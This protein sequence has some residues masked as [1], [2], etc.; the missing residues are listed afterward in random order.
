MPPKKSSAEEA[1]AWLKPILDKWG[2]HFERF[3]RIFEIFLQMQET[4]N[5]ILNKLESLERRIS[6]EAD[7]NEGS[8]SALYSTLVK[9]KADSRIV[10]EKACMDHMGGYFIYI[11]AISRVNE[12]RSTAWTAAEERALKNPVLEALDRMKAGMDEM[13]EQMMLMRR[14]TAGALRELED[15]FSSSYDA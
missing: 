7:R 15:E 3:D 10:D 2:E 5:I 9:F 13:L 1:P 14:S 11:M 8:R 4:Q 12:R 6:M